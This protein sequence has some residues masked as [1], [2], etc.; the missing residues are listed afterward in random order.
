MDIFWYLLA[1]Q[2]GGGGG[3]TLLAPTIAQSGS[4]LTLSNPSGNGG[5][6]EYF[7]LYNGDELIT[8]LPISTTTFDLNTLDVGDYTIT[9][10]CVGTGMTESPKSS[11]AITLSVYAVTLALTDI[12]AS[13]AP[14]KI[15]SNV[16]ITIALSTSGV[17]V[18]PDS[19]SVSGAT[20]VFTRTN[21]TSGSLALSAPTGAVTVTAAALPK[22]A[23][24]SISL[25]GDTLTI[26]T[27]DFNTQNYGIYSDNV[28]VDTVPR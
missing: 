6:A 25:S 20:G 7:N 3:A 24:P 9:A 14:T 19:V 13:P 2:R 5:F 10:T 16:A 15:L 23:A 12:T 17:Y 21:D 22:L 4:N 18:L 28:L 26:E 11:A 27:T 1:R 8:T